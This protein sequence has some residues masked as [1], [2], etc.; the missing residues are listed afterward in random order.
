MVGLVCEKRSEV[1]KLF[2]GVGGLE[3]WGEYNWR[4]VD[5]WEVK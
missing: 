4:N 3:G 1:G 5:N 2:D